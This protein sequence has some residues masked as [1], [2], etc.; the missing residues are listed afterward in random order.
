MSIGTEAE[1]ILAKFV[2]EPLLIDF[3]HLRPS[4]T[5]GRE[6][7]D[8]LIEDEPIGIPIQLKAQDLTVAKPERDAKRWA[9]KNLREANSQ[10][11][12]AIRTLSREDI[13]VSSPSRGAITF[14]A[15]QLRASH[16][17]A[18]VDYEGAPFK[19]PMDLNR[20]RGRGASIHQLSY[21]DFI[22]L[23]QHLMTLP[24]LI[25]YLNERSNIPSWSTP[26]LNNEKDAYAYYTTH[27]GKF[28][29]TIQL[30][31][32]QGQWDELVSDGSHLY[33]EK[34]RADKYAEL[35]ARILSTL[36]E[37]V[38]T[39]GAVVPEYIRGQ[40]NNDTTSRI[41]VARSLNRI[42]RV[43]R[44]EISKKLIEKGKLASTSKQ[45]FNYCAFLSDDRRTMFL[46]LASRNDRTKRLEEMSVLLRCLLSIYEIDFAIGV[47]TEDMPSKVG[48]SFDFLMMDKA[49]RETEPK[50]V[51][52]CKKHFGD[53]NL[54]R[55]NDFP[56]Q[57]GRLIIP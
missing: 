1:N 27:K 10:I 34:L 37:S 36:H 15:G 6:L 7:C 22:I 14:K 44:R 16:G 17:L 56:S 33:D 45:G 54:Q 35:F 23:C 29:P 32:I 9:L 39:E 13:C 57:S 49:F 3:V 12:G 18:I 40:L 20:R 21:K 51:D 28:P 8:V 52:I 47:G 19:I 48:R 41:M 24:D 46:F 2:S 26:E 5:N 55:H 4:R 11:N 50:L 38:P 25:D 53:L 42:R 30:A 43:A 31:D